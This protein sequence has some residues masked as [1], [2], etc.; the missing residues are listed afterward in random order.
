M[1]WGEC[2][3]ILS[4]QEMIA[5][6]SKQ[7]MLGFEAGAF[8]HKAYHWFCLSSF[9]IT[10]IL[11]CCILGVFFNKLIEKKSFFDLIIGLFVIRRII[12]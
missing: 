4:F 8:Q 12:V 6:I 5:P 2:K 7:I 9:G 11:P 10:F 3:A 1:G